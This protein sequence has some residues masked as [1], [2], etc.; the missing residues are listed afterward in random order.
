MRRIISLT[1]KCTFNPLDKYIETVDKNTELIGKLEKLYEALLAS[2]REKV[3][4][5]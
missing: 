3:A 2:E 1:I 5:L 4:L